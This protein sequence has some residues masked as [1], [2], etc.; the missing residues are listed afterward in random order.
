MG[1]ILTL[2]RMYKNQKQKRIQF[3]KAKTKEK[4]P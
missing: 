3:P 2:L 4:L 1:T